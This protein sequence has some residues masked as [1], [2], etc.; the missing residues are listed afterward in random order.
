MYLYLQPGSD[1][2][3]LRR[4]TMHTHQRSGCVARLTNPNQEAFNR[5]RIKSVANDLIVGV[6]NKIDPCLMGLL[7]DLPMKSRSCNL[8]IIWQFQWYGRNFIDTQSLGSRSHPSPFL[9][10]P[11]MKILK[12]IC[13]LTFLSTEIDAF[14]LRVIIAQPAN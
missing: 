5:K 8:E 11:V 4:R 12:E 9:F 2:W 1:F 7:S 10:F 14:L 3:K 6:S 13:K